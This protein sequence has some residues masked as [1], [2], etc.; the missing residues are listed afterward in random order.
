MFSFVY[1]NSRE[2]S[3]YMARD[4]AGEKP[5]YYALYN[6][7]ILFGSEIKTITDFPLF[8]SNLNYSSIADYLHLDYVSLD[9]TIINDIKK[10]MPGEYVKYC[11]T[12]L[13]K[14]YYWKYSQENKVN[15]K[16]KEILIH[17]DNLINISVIIN[18]HPWD[19]F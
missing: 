9:K 12:K 3:V 10:V 8:K 13:T 17:L 4:R 7:H 15:I 14:N 19:L 5:L 1:Y 6:N 2:N 11:D 18:V 16:E